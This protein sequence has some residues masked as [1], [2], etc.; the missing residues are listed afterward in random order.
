MYQGREV[1]VVGDQNENHFRIRQGIRATKEGRVHPFYEVIGA[2][3]NNR[4]ASSLTVRFENGTTAQAPV[5][6]VTVQSN[7]RDFDSS[8][9]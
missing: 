8:S 5:S 3:A 1:Q 2:V 7:I 4:Q 6:A 9:G